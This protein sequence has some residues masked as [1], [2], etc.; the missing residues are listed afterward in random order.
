VLA[1][2]GVISGQSVNEDGELDLPAEQVPPVSYTLIVGLAY[3][4]KAVTLRP[5]VQNGPG[6]FQGFLQRIAQAFL[7]VIET[8]AIKA[9]A[10][11]ADVPLEDQIDRPANGAMDAQIPAFTGDVKVLVSREPIRDTTMTLISDTPL[12]A[13]IAMMSFKI[14]SGDA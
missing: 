14:E 1:G 7:R 11:N 2:G 8:V 3:E 4:A 13:T 5:Y 9:G 12:P 10:T 6:G